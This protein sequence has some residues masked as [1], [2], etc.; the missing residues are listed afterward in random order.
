[1]KRIFTFLTAV[2]LLSGM[3]K[4]WAGGTFSLPFTSENVTDITFK[5]TGYTSQSGTKFKMQGNG[6]GNISI[7]VKAESAE[8]WAQ[9][10]TEA[11][12]GNKE[13]SLN[14]DFQSAMTG[15]AIINFKA[16]DGYSL[17]EVVIEGAD[18]I[19]TGMTATV[20]AGEEPDPTPS[21]GPDP[22]DDKTTATVWTG[23]LN[24]GAWAD[25]LSLIFSGAEF[26]AG[27]VIT[28]N[29]TG[30]QTG[31]Q[32]QIGYENGTDSYA[33]AMNGI[34]NY[35]TIDAATEHKLTLD[36]AW[37]AALNSGKILRVNGNNITVSGVT[38]T[39]AKTEGVTAAEPAPVV[40]VDPYESWNKFV[41]DDNTE[42]SPDAW[43]LYA[44]VVKQDGMAEIQE[45]DVLCIEFTTSSGDLNF[46]YGFKCKEGDSH[47]GY[48]V[49]DDVTYGYGAYRYYGE[50]DYTTDISS[51]YYITV[52]EVLATQL[53]SGNELW[54]RGTGFALNKITLMQ[55]PDR[56]RFIWV[57]L[58]IPDASM[59]GKKNY[60]YGEDKENDMKIADWMG[61]AKV[62][63]MPAGSGKYAIKMY[64][65]WWD[66]DE[67]GKILN[68]YDGNKAAHREQLNEQHSLPVRIRRA[69][70]PNLALIKVGDMLRIDVTC[71]TDMGDDSNT[72]ETCGE[73]SSQAQLGTY[74]PTLTPGPDPEKPLQA[75]HPFTIGDADEDGNRANY[76]E[77]GVTNE[78]KIIDFEIGAV[79]LK[80]ITRYGLSINGRKFYLNSVKAKVYIDDD[81]E[82]TE[83]E[84]VI[85][86]Y[87]YNTTIPGSE[88]DKMTENS[89]VYIYF[90]D[91]D[92]YTE[93]RVA[94]YQD[95]D[96]NIFIGYQ[97]EYYDTP[98]K[99]DDPTRWA[100]PEISVRFKN[101][102]QGE[103]TWERLHIAAY[104]YDNHFPVPKKDEEAEAKAMRAPNKAK[105]DPNAVYPIDNVAIRAYKDETT[106]QKV[107]A[108]AALD[109]TLVQRI[110]DN[111]INLRGKKFVNVSDVRVDPTLTG[112]LGVETDNTDKS[113]DYNAPYEVYNLQGMRVSEPV[114]GMLHIVRQGNKVE[115]VIIR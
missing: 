3:V 111:G 104:L 49:K 28:L 15:T 73:K 39:S 54:L 14:D 112:I 60:G 68:D 55:R 108:F 101:E 10:I 9:T 41:V 113:I 103:L 66:T 80:Y 59:A 81:N 99:M 93:H 18:A 36:E 74:D 40:P 109:P 76:K 110:K 25:G 46:Q 69:N 106:G 26:K 42:Y 98:Q 100:E 70:T 30:T 19:Q 6:K 5:I 16:T 87:F 86:D 29:L 91:G 56:R 7:S 48:V 32:I 20:V 47:A 71:Y 107:F 61:T 94:K 77:W 79:M 95:A 43:Q 38:I 11:A 67:S 63:E 90:E 105:E 57:D 37:A 72:I 52:D 96:K 65:E 45:G 58:L 2:L 21:P 22:G 33:W 78:N 44:K 62:V 102:V 53:E 34:D 64:H 88:F 50:N 115:K 17:K 92:E 85:H 114:P 24:T 12:D 35:F 8:A 31:S 27:D 82:T 84:H 75:F 13:I 51:P 4:T 97:T 83:T 23:T 1:M 89:S